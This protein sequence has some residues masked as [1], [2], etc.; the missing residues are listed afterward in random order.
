MSDVLVVEVFECV[1]D[2]TTR[3][4][5]S[6]DA[7]TK[8]RVVTFLHNQMVCMAYE[9]RMSEAGY[10]D[11]VLGRLENIPWNGLDFAFSVI[12]LPMSACGKVERLM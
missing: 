5:F 7:T 2:F 9:H 8:E 10:S 11:E 3:T 4:L 6:V 1:C 12:D